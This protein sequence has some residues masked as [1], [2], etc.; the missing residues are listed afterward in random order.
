MSP[1]IAADTIIPNKKGKILIIKRAKYPFKGKWV[2]PGGKTKPNEEVE[3]T[4]TRETKEET[5]IEIELKDL[6]GIYSDPNRDPRGRYI[7]VA[8]ISKPTD[9]KEIKTNEEASE[10]QWINPEKIK[11]KHM[12]FDHWK[13]IQD[14]LNWKKTNQS[15]WSTKNK[16]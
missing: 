16:T 5:G 11:E 3:K 12:G 1:Q 8:F 9:K 7:S 15:A 6:L 14:Y 4:S 13:M 2:L 10:H